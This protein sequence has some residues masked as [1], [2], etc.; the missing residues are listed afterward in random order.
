MVRSLKLTRVA[1][2]VLAVVAAGG[3]VMV[4]N[5]ASAG[6]PGTLGTK[7]QTLAANAG[8]DFSRND[9]TLSVNGHTFR[10]TTSA[11]SWTA[12]FNSSSAYDVAFY[13]DGVQLFSGSEQNLTDSDLQK[14]I[15]ALGTVG[16]QQR[17]ST[18]VLRSE[19]QQVTGVV[20]RRI[21]QI[22]V[23][24]PPAAMGTRVK[25]QKA[26]LGTQEI[27]ESNG[28]VGI[29]AGDANRFGVWGSATYGWLDN[30]FSSTKYDGDLMAGVGGVDYQIGRAVVGAA[31][32]VEST[33]LDTTFNG[34]T[35]KKQGFSITPYAAYSMMDGRLVLDV[36]AGY[37]TGDNRSTH[38]A[39][40]TRVTGNYDS[41]RIML[42]SHAT[43]TENF[44]DWNVGGKVGYM[45]SREKADG[46]TQSDSTVI[47]SSTTKLGEVGIGPRVGYSVGGFEPYASATYL[48]DVT[49]TK[50]RIAG[51][52]V[53]A[54]PNDRDEVEGIIG[55]N[56]FPADNVITGF[57]LAHGFFR[58]KTNNTS[59]TVNA[60]ITF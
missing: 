15:D 17:T 34:G 36:L 21:S 42:G 33:D 50:T 59:V 28:I 48:Y 2:A 29:S 37:G 39:G 53:A 55:V 10:A 9:G 31:L 38:S 12:D 16:A 27:V 41:T 43:Y 22:L 24:R 26:G 19:S 56:Y 57:E 54:P 40:A 58:E 18:E 60:R 46:Y 51:N 49:M 6:S 20:A 3:V 32:S 30:S 14:I 23:I 8:A 25:T 45:W 47:G 44:G 5:A 52:T 1:R 11:S 13:V 35:F 4:S 7:L